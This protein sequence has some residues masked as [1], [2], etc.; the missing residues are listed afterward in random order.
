VKSRSRVLRV[1]DLAKDTLGKGEVDE[2]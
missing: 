2:P 1:A